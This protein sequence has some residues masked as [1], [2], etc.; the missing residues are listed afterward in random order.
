MQTIAYSQSKRV[1]QLSFP[2][3]EE[4]VSL[5]R[6]THKSDFSD[7]TFMVNKTLPIHRWVPW[8]AGFSSSFVKDALRKYSHGGMVLDPF[9]GVGTTLLDA[10]VDGCDSI[11]FEINPY[12]V[13]ACRVKTSFHKIDVHK[14]SQEILAFEKFYTRKVNS[15]YLPRS[16]A[17][18]GFKTRHRFY[19]EPVLRK[20]L[21]VQDFMYSLEDED[22]R[23]VFRLAFA[24]N[25]IKFSNY[26]YEPSLSTR[27]SAGK[28]DI[29]D[30]PVGQLLMEKLR[31]MLEEIKWV[32]KN[33]SDK[34]STARVINDS[35]FNYEKY[36]SPE[37]IELI[38]TSPPYLN[39]YHYNRNTRPHLYWLNL[40]NS[41]K[42]FKELE[43]E[44]VGK[45]W[46][47]VREKKRIDLK[48]SL[49]NT[50]LEEK[51]EMLRELNLEKGIYGG[52]GWANYATTYFN[53]CYRFAKGIKFSLK[54]GGIALVVIGNSIL[55]GIMIQTDQYFGKI[56]ESI[57]LELVDIEIPR[58]ER[59]GNSII[60][61]DVRVEKAKKAD[62][63]YEA[64]VKLRKG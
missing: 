24:S 4:G 31:E 52:N 35:F 22:L 50:D 62:K 43:H 37:S 54:K 47:T 49:H 38:I 1:E 57:G 41:P 48:F 30:F 14:L 28:D 58:K 7:T 44:N 33:S 15:G 32:N 19:S 63:L 40:V 17:P 23:D 10:I 21:I 60:K 16:K 18:Q 12:A 34:N 64:V 42:D 39:N 5:T 46:Q 2:I 8:I 25:M 3:I 61:S 55:Q 51:L 9:A 53:D 20:V 56:A 59:V 27:A 6:K 26:S 11:G 36:V 45:Y 13:L 29:H